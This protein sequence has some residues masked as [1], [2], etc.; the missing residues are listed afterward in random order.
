M[1][2]T[3]FICGNICGPSIEDDI[4]LSTPNESQFSFWFDLPI[5]CNELE[6]SKVLQH[7]G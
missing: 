1:Y 7:S 3:L 4:E 2:K 6:F 5:N